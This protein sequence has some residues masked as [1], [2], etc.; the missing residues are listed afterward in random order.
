M[1]LKKSLTC[2]IGPE[3]YRFGRMGVDDPGTNECEICKF[4]NNETNNCDLSD[5]KQDFP[6]FRQLY[7]NFWTIGKFAYLCC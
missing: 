7:K 1:L 2:R 5:I 6:C 4:S 3:V